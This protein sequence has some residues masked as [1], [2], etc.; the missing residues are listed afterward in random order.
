MYFA[1]HV[2]NHFVMGRK[3]GIALSNFCVDSQTY[4]SQTQ[5]LKSNFYR[6][7]SLADIC[8]L[9]NTQNIYPMV[10][11]F[12]MENIDVNYSLIKV[13]PFLWN[14]KSHS[15]CIL[16]SDKKS[17]IYQL[18]GLVQER[19]NSIANTLEL[20]LSCTNPSK[21]WCIQYSNDTSLTWLTW[22]NWDYGMDK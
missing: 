9:I 7:V 1:C 20:H 15:C 19:R 12:H 14:C 18:Y 8:C 22:F 4:I 13:Y 6:I 10:Y 11:H 16:K 5:F 21:W 17:M 3:H 2:W